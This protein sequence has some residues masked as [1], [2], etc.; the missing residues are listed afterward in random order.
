MIELS[1]VTA[2]ITSQ[3]IRTLTGRL[4]TEEQIKR[5][6][7]HS[8]GKHFASLFPENDDERSQRERIEE[9]LGHIDSA[10]TIMSGMRGELDAQKATLE[11]LLQEIEEKKSTAE[12]YAQ[13]AMTH[14]DKVTA[15]RTELENTVRDELIRQ[16][17]QGRRL[18]LAVS[19]FMWV[20]TL[21]L[22]AALGTY[23]KEFWELCRG[24]AAWII[25][26]LSTL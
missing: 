4:F 16:S 5:I 10:T 22:G 17:N 23:F 21:F 3:A 18:R 11:R 15:I 9:A 19:I 26:W 20:A 7:E 13:L 6:S 1:A 14:E 25:A 12:H 24:F 2:E 8:V